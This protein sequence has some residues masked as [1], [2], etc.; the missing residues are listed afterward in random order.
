MDILYLEGKSPLLMSSSQVNFRDILPETSKSSA[1]W[2]MGVD[3]HLKWLL[4]FSPDEACESDG[5][6]LGTSWVETW[7]KRVADMSR[8][9]PI[10]PVIGHTLRPLYACTHNCFCMIRPAKCYRTSMTRDMTTTAGHFRYTH[11][12]IRHPLVAMSE[13]YLRHSVR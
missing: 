13:P 7:L 4:L 12:R 9:L 5:T 8:L 6:S 10:S 2:H 3:S 11:S 1:F